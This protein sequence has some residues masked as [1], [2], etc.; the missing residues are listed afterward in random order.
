MISTE[1]PFSPWILEPSYHPDWFYESP[2]PSFPVGE[3]VNDDRRSLL[4]YPLIEDIDFWIN[5]PVAVDTPGVGVSCSLANASIWNVHNHLRFVAEQNSTPVAVT[6]ICA[7]PE[8][9]ATWAFTLLSFEKFQFIGGPKF[10]SLYTESH[11]KLCLSANPVQTDYYVLREMNRNRRASR[12]EEIPLTSPLFKYG[13]ALGLGDYSG[14]SVKPYVCADLFLSVSLRVGI[15]ISMEPE[16]I[17]S[18]LPILIQIVLA[19]VM[20]F[21]ILFVSHLF[22][23]RSRGNQFKD[24]P[25]ECGLNP[26]GKSQSRFAVKFY[27]T[28]MLFIL[29]DI[30]VVFM[31]PGFW[32]SA[33]LLPA[34]YLF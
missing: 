22:G 20:G 3:K 34:V 5:L 29:F 18:Y 1:S 16:S 4:P 2:L 14:N 24:A 8:L 9:R 25:Y 15:S 17:T 11:K 30:E 19:L 13:Q 12:F 7:I 27:V 23:Q 26:A 21:G 32:F 33:T 6:E 28:A 31:I 10:H